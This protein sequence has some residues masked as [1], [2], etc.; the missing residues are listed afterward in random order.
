MRSCILWL[1]AACGVQDLTSGADSRAVKPP[2]DG[3]RTVFVNGAALSNATQQ[4][5]RGDYGIYFED[6]RFWYDDRSGLAGL[7]EQ[8][9]AGILP[10]GLALGGALDASASSGDSGTFINGR[11]LSSAEVLYLSQLG[12]VYAVH[13]WLDADGSFGLEPDPNLGITSALYIDN[14]YRLAIQKGRGSGSDNYHANGYTNAYSNSQG[15]CS[16]VMTDS[17]TATSGCG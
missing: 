11:E 9:P 7:E 13:Y 6:G 8:P 16:Y 2:V 14:L 1:V 4:R 10:P 3:D 12:D 15:G 5:L 17:G